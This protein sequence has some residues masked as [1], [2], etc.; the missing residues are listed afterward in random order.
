MTET[1]RISSDNQITLSEETLALLG[2]KAGDQVEIV[3]TGRKHLAIRPRQGTLADLKGIV[4]LEQPV[5]DEE[6][7]RW[8]AEARGR[9]FGNGGDR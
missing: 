2:V 6:L 5:T 4:R 3:A 9:L 7:G 8:V 1:V